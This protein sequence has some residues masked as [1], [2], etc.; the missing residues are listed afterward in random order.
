MNNNN[1]V[2]PF[3]ELNKPGIDLNQVIHQAQKMQTIF[4][5]MGVTEAKFDTGTRYESTPEKTTVTGDGVMVQMRQHTTA[6]IFRNEGSSEKD[7][8]PE[9]RQIATQKDA[10]AFS[11]LTQPSISRIENND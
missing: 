10:A 8:I 6:V 5:Q 4:R 7:A 1:E 3:D 2:L 9:I 11:N